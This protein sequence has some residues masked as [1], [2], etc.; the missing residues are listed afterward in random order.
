VT[1]RRAVAASFG[2]HR[3]Y[4]ST[5]HQCSKYKMWMALRAPRPPLLLLVATVTLLLAYCPAAAGSRT[6]MQASPGAVEA[7]RPLGSALVAACPAASTSNGEGEGDGGVERR[8]R[9]GGAAAAPARRPD[10]ACFDARVYKLVTGV[11]PGR[12]CP[13]CHP[14]RCEPW[15]PGILSCKMASNIYWALY[16]GARRAI[17]A[18]RCVYRRV[19]GVPR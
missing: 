3:E 6:L 12:H 7:W 14:T 17:G 18:V 8:G 9:G 15:Q 10:Q 16:W 1:P 4:V 5:T 11:K 13:S 19:L 2:A